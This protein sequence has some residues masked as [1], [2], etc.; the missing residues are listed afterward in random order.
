[1]LLITLENGELQADKLVNPRGSPEGARVG[2]IRAHASSPVLVG[3]FGAGLALI[4]PVN[5]TLTTIALP[6]IPLAFAFDHHGEHIVVLTRDG[7]LHVLELDGEIV[8]SLEVV[9][10]F[11]PDAPRSGLAVSWAAVYVSSPSTGEILEVHVHDG[12]L[13]VARRLPAPGAPSSIVV[14]AMEGGVIH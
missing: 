8:A 3:N 1:V 11:D 9:A 12:R 7:A 13:E 5:Q 6:G 10:P 4:D 2:T 14:L